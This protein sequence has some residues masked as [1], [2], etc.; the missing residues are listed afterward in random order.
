[1]K[2]SYQ[3]LALFV[4]MATNLMHA[5]LPPANQPVPNDSLIHLLPGVKDMTQDEIAKLYAEQISLAEKQAHDNNSKIDDI[6]EKDPKA[7]EKINEKTCP[8]FKP[9]Q[10][11]SKL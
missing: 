5:S 10:N 2:I 11:S 3:I 9:G 6:F 1:M 4:P 7:Q 8:G